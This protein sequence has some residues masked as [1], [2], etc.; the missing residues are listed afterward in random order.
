MKINITPALLSTSGA[1]K[2]KMLPGF[3]LQIS[4]AHGHISVLSDSPYSPAKHSITDFVV[5]ETE[6]RKGFG[7]ELLKEA[8]RRFGEDLGGQASST[9]SIALMHKLGFRMAS[10]INS[11]VHDAIAAMREGSS[12]YMRHKR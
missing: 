12:V 10:N 11:T 7:E 4:S 2:T 3:G 5:S 9:A 1:F 6:R 8:V